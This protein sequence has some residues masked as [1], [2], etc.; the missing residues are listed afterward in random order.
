MSRKVSLVK[1]QARRATAQM[2]PQAEMAMYI[3][4]DLGI[5]IDAETLRKFIADRFTV[6]SILAHEIWE[7]TL[8]PGHPKE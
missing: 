6:L 3:R 8:Q 2:S 5:E 4:K 7:P 1:K